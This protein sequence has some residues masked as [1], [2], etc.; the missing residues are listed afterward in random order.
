MTASSV[1][2]QLNFYPISNY[3][4][5]SVITLLSISSCFRYFNCI[6]II[7]NFLSVIHSLLYFDCFHIRVSCQFY[8]VTTHRHTVL[9]SDL[10]NNY[11]IYWSTWLG[12]RIII[13]E[14]S[15]GYF[16]PATNQSIFRLFKYKNKVTNCIFWIVV[17][18]LQFFFSNITFIWQSV[19]ILY[20]IFKIIF[21]LSYF[22]P[23]HRSY[24]RLLKIFFMVKII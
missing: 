20:V 5:T 7:S 9:D 4:V 10:N 2:I 14:M 8:F 23:L 18:Y 22:S 3:Q 6:A 19:C 17:I 24:Y 12:N 13:N 11:N 1:I 15:C 16:S 21:S